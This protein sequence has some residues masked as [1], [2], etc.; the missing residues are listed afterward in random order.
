[1]CYTAYAAAAMYICL[2]I[3]FAMGNKHSLV[4]LSIAAFG[5]LL[6]ETTDWPFGPHHFASHGPPMSFSPGPPNV[7]NIGPDYGFAIWQ[8]TKNCF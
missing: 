6:Q 2:L 7:V 4:T 1:M 3:F 8:M 5:I